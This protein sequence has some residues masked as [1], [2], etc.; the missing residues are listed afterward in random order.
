MNNHL[1]NPFRDILNAFAVPGTKPGYAEWRRRNTLFRAQMEIR[2]YKG[3]RAG[4]FEV[5]C[6][7]RGCQ[8]GRES[9]IEMER[10]T[11]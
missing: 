8:A 11:R 6:S 4:T 9:T 3:M 2:H 1:A 7:C 5:A 10:R